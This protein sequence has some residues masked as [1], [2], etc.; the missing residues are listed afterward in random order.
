[1]RIRVKDHFVQKE[2]SRIPEIMKDLMVD[3][4]DKLPL[5][6]PT[7]MGK[8][9]PVHQVIVIIE[10]RVLHCLLVSSQAIISRRYTLRAV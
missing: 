10:S 1:M 5:V 7:L 4:I 3:F 8:R 2:I 9:T 6:L